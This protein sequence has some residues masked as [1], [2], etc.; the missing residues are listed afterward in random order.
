MT[1]TRNTSAFWGETWRL[2]VQAL[3]A[4]K[5]RAALTMLGVVIGSG[6]IVL[7]VTVALAGQH[8]V[9]GQIEG[10]GANLVYA[11]VVNSEV[12]GSFAIADQITPADLAAVREGIPQLVVNAA[13]TNALPMSVVVN[14]QERPV[15]LV[16]ATAGFERIRNLAIL[17]GRYFDEDEIGS[18]GKV[19]LLTEALARRVFPFQDP[20]G[21]EVRVGELHFTVIGVF[22]ERVAALGQTEITRESVLIPFSL[23]QYFTGAQYFNTLYVQADAPE[24]VPSVTRE[25][26]EIL[27]GRHRPGARYRVQ[28]LA[29]ILETAR[30]IA[31]A[32]AAVL[33]LIALIALVISGVGIMNIMLVTVTERTREIGIRK[34]I[35]ASRDAILYQFLMEALAISGTGALAGILIAVLIPSLLSFLIGF[36]PEAEGITVP[37]SWISVLLAFVVSCST[38]LVFGYL[39]ASRA[40]RLQ[41]TESLHHE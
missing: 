23:I 22:K 31:L 8:Y 18:R 10:V 24:D 38:G 40:A 27:A 41:P 17:R 2:A 39:P 16:G 34:A 29:G 3:R 7:V 11:N 26:A 32:L 4:N 35:G 9:L 25:V 13:G 15:N 6:S 14:G 20:D 36:F 28:N 30:N 37:V 12:A 5:L 21:Q 19:C 1:S 33:I